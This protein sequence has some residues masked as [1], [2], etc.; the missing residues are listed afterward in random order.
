M[1]Q[2]PMKPGTIVKCV[3][4][5]PASGVLEAGKHYKVAVIVG[6]GYDYHG[7]AEGVIV[8]PVDFQ[9]EKIGYPYVWDTDRFEVV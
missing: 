5:Y 9:R 7:Y 4:G 8:V 6:S 2:H 3:R 1:H